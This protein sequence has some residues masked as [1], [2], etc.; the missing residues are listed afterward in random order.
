VFAMSHTSASRQRHRQ[1]RSH[2]DR[3]IP[4]VLS[5]HQPATRNIS[6][7]C[8]CVSAK[9]SEIASFCMCVCLC[10]CVRARA[11]TSVCVGG[12][13]GVFLCGCVCMCEHTHAHTC[14]TKN[15]L[16]DLP[17]IPCVYMKER[18]RESE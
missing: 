9:V 15:D 7:S 8:A 18:E 10:V 3:S 5:Q 16:E 11:R 1:N 12:R 17:R 14:Y 13:G 4:E 2:Q 6:A